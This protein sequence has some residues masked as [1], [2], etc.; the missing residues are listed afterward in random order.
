MNEREIVEVINKI[1]Q[2][3]IKTADGATAMKFEDAVHITY[4]FAT[5]WMPPD[6]DLFD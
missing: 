5:D 4:P 3:F 2:E 1:R 6:E